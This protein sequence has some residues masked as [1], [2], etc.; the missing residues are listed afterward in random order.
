MIREL[1][2]R[3]FAIIDSLQ[4][5]FGPGMTVLTGET[6]AG[7]SILV[8]ALGLVLG[9][10]SDSSFVAGG[11]KQTE[12]SVVFEQ[13]SDEL[14]ALLVELG[15]DGQQAGEQLLIRRTVQIGGRSS[16]WING[17]RVPVR[18]LSTLGSALAD[19]H[20]QHSHQALLRRDVQCR[21][22]DEF[23]GHGALRDTLHQCY[24]D[25]RQAETALA[26][27]LQQQGQDN[28]GQI[29]LLHYQ[30][31][32]LQARQLG[33]HE[34]QQLLTDHRRLRNAQR[35][36]DTIQAALA[37]LESGDNALLDRLREIHNNLSGILDFVPQLQPVHSLLEEVLVQGTEARDDLRTLWQQ[38]DLEPQQLVD[39]EQRLGIWHELARKHQ[40]P[41]TELYARQGQ[42]AA[43]LAQ[44]EQNSEQQGAL[45]EH[46]QARLQ[47]WRTLAEQMHEAR[48][49]C[50]GDFASQVTRW[51]HQLGMPEGRFEVR[52]ARQEAA[53][54][55]PW[56]LDSLEFLLATN[57][58]QEP[59]PLHKVASGGELSRT[60]LAIQ[61]VARG[62]RGMPVLVCDEVD[63][64]IGG[65]TAVI[66]G[67]L[68]AG[69]AQYRQVLCV[70]HLPQIA[71]RAGWHYRVRKQQRSRRPLVTIEMLDETDRVEEIARM[72]SGHEHGD[73]GRAH[74]RAMLQQGSTVPGVS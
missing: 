53:T 46:Y 22:L 26:A 7:K 31:E 68:L 59:L 1:E 44:L 65:D 18:T 45:Q 34:Y 35:V 15:I 14:V 11:H 55:A 17:S 74:A 62:T 42:L 47:E 39:V 58:G 33:E 23:S 20:G 69:L 3:N 9:G 21:L 8:D 72:I 41:E 38:L 70:S 51:M 27:S 19:I 73:T 57:R 56:G 50:V 29:A 48:R 61:I 64:G 25:C 24:I 67:Q 5:E 60:S 49:A 40:V 43:R 54:P 66:V 10:R 71:S 12:L 52:L 36:A 13:L 63:V 4:L 30:L 2:I 32:E 37:A 28:Q 6:G 16:A